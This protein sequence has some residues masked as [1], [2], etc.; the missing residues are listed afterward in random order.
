M[1]KPGIRREV[2]FQSAAE[3]CPNR[4][5][6][7]VWTNGGV[8]GVSPAQQQVLYGLPA[9][10]DARCQQRVNFAGTR[11]A[12]LAAYEDRLISTHINQL[13]KYTEEIALLTANARMILGGHHP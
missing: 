7:T 13:R 6:K 10:A 12:V 2:R 9:G 5:P 11:L 1:A 8:F 4:V 3:S